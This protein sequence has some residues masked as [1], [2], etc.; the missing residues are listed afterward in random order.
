MVRSITHSHDVNATAFCAG[1]LTLLML[2]AHL[3]VEGGD[4]VN[5]VTL[6]VDDVDTSAKS[7]DQHVRH[8]PLVE[9]AV[10]RSGRKGVLEGRSL[11]RVFA[12]V[13]PN[14]LVWN[15]GVNN[16]LMGLIPPAFDVLA[17]NS[18]STNL[19]AAF[20]AEFTNLIVDNSLQTNGAVIAA[21]DAGRP[22]HRE[23]RPLH[24]RRPST[25]TSCPGPPPTGPGDV[26]RPPV[27][28]LQQR[29]HPGADQPARQP[30]GDLPRGRVYPAEPD[31]WL[32]GATTHRGSWW[33]DWVAWTVARSGPLKR[34]PARLGRGKRVALA[35]CAGDLCPRRLTT[36][37]RRS[38]SSVPAGT[39]SVSRS[40]AQDR[41]SCS[42]WASAE[43]PR[44]GNPCGVTC[45]TGD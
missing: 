28:A 27:R 26:G 8:P 40:T 37:R 3:A 42:S 34:R 2:L 29:P 10:A 31:E 12:W 35:P 1:G 19:P 30:E 17:W 43:T 21:R 18:D 25:T 13:R 24:R 23:E 22:R 45:R 9:V 5:A 4:L 33:T 15:Y 32:A 7:V 36:P 20:H 39:A 44:C 6:G 16:Y 11:A 14:D 41:H 38:P